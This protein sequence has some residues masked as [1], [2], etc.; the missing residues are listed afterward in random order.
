MLKK[1]HLQPNFSEDTNVYGNIN[2][3]ENTKRLQR[4]VEMLRS[5]E[6]EIFPS[7]LEISANEDA[8]LMCKFDKPE[9]DLTHTAV[10]WAFGSQTNQRDMYVFDGGD[11][12]PK[13]NGAKMFDDALRKGNASLY[14]PNVQ[15]DEAGVYTCIVI[16]TPQKEQ[17]S[18]VMQVSAQPKVSMYQQ[19]IT[20]ADGTGHFLVCDVKE[21]YPK[22]V[23][24]SWLM[25]SD[26]KIEY[27][28][29]NQ[30]IEDLIT[31]SDGTFSVSSKIR[32]EPTLDDRTNYRCVVKHKTFLGN[33]TL[34]SDQDEEQIPKGAIIGGI[35]GIVVF[36]AAC[37]GVY[38]W[39]KKCKEPSNPEE[40]EDEGSRAFLLRV[41]PTISDIKKPREISDGEETILS[42][43]ITVFRPEVMNIVTSVKRKGQQEA[44]KLFHWK[45]S[46]ELL[47]GPKRVTRPLKNVLHLS[48]KDD[49]FSADTP[50]F[51]RK[52]D[53]SFCIP[54]S[55]TLRPDVSKDDGAELIIEVKQD[56][57]EETW[58]KSTIL[59]VTAGPGNTGKSED[60]SSRAPLG[61]G[62]GKPGKSEDESS[63]APLVRVPPT[64]SDIKKPREIID[65]EETILRWDVTVS[66]PEV[67]NIVTSVKR[68][69]QQETKKL[70]DWKISAELLSG[71]KRVTRPLKNVLHLSEK[72][73]SFSADTPEFQRKSDRSFCIPCSITLR[74]DVSKDDGAELIIEVKQD[75]SEETWTKSTVLKLT[76]GQDKSKEG[77]DEPGR[78]D[79]E[80]TNVSFERAGF[81]SNLGEAREDN[82]AE[83]S[84]QAQT[85]EEENPS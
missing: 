25:L 44:K 29:K 56:A 49:S 17:K 8:L 5:L 2:Y 48:K 15:L 13:R 82:E 36:C 60:E 51:Q 16:V 4:D 71:P 55:I 52:S 20:T 24:I 68:K 40:S 80:K 22:Q 83:S 27:I 46:A 57:S 11:H 14:L 39:I 42:W 18:S 54:C 79:F 12:Y 10:R 53:R 47:S 59:K 1:T 21:F 37:L 84:D 75:A 70:F 76:A 38:R 81:P 63:R 62:P 32:I 58:T 7:P 72:D 61:K 35:C 45:I 69:G 9:Y 6:L 34:D 41:P 3:E 64:I 19:E 65:G 77:K 43:D 78:T 74:P 30:S 73:D 26:G 28:S 23:N 31:N 50:E 85:E 33:F 66:R 67:M